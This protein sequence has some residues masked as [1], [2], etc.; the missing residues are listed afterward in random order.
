MADAV[1]LVLMAVP[2]VA[3]AERLVE[4]LVTERHAACGSIVPGATSI[5]WWKGV[6]EKSAEALVVLK[7][8]RAAT[9][10]L[11]SRAA[12]LHPYE[13]PE[14]LVVALDGGHLPYLD[15]VR[16]EVRTD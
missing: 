14:L 10:D 7:T 2:D 4:T 11:L 5:Y 9:E 12:E 13:V 1:R 16:T 3:T 15:W 8:T 6:L